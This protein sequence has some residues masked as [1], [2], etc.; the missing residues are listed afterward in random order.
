[1]AAL[2]RFAQLEHCATRDDLATVRQE[3]LNHLLQVK[4]SWLTIHQRH[5]V[6]PKG[7]LQL[8]VLI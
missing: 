3:V 1:M 6:H 8:G 7:I 2:A 4:Q 5:Q